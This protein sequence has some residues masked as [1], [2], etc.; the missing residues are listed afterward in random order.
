M[1]LPRC[2]QIEFDSSGN[3]LMG[4][5]IAESHTESGDVVWIIQ[6]TDTENFLSVN[7]RHIGDE[8]TFDGPPSIAVNIVW[9]LRYTLGLDPIK[10]GDYRYVDRGSLRVEP[11]TDND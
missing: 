6:E 2:V 1:K 5:V 11:I 3:I 9:P 10:R 8:L 7:Y 4:R